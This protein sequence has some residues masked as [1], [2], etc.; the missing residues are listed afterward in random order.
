MPPQ[1]EGKHAVGSPGTG[2]GGK[3]FGSLYVA[4]LHFHDMRDGVHRPAILRVQGNG[5]ATLFFGLAVIP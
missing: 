4:A 2:A 3:V 5:F 1:M